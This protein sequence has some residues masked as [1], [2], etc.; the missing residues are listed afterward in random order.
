MRRTRILAACVAASLAGALIA[1]AQEI[2][3]PRVYVP[4]PPAPNPASS[5]GAVTQPTED[6]AAPGAPPPLSP[7]AAGAEV[8]PGE[9]QAVVSPSP[10]GR[11][12]GSGPPDAAFAASAV[13]ASSFSDLVDGI[14][15]E[16]GPGEALGVTGPRPT[17]PGYGL[18]A[19]S[20][21]AQIA[22]DAYQAFP[23]PRLGPTPVANVRIL[24]N[25]LGLDPLEEWS[26][27]RTFGWVEGGYTGASVGPGLLSVQTRQNRFGDEFLLNQIGWVIEKPLRSDQFDL[28][29]V[30]RYFAGADAALGAPKGGI[31]SS[32]NPHFGQDFRDL[33]LSMHLPVLTENGVDFR[34]GRMNTIIGYNG[35]LAPY[36]PFY[37]SDYQFF[38]LQDG[39]FTGFLLDFKIS[40]RLSIWSGMTLGANTFFVNRT[41]NSYCYIGQVNYWLT[42]E[43]R[44]R[45]TAS[46]YTGP[47]ALFS[48]PGLSG[49]HDTMVE[50]RMQ[51]AWSPRLTQ[52]IQS[53]MGW[54]SGTP[55]G[56]SGAYGVY[57]I[58]LYHFT[59]TLDINWRSEWFDDAMGTRT[60][61]KANYAE[62]TGGLNWHPLRWLE[63][64]P[65]IR[66]D[67][68]DA[69]V[70]GRNGAHNYRDMLTG[71]ISFLTKF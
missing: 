54:D 25:L 26:N 55:V 22:E 9:P 33:Y 29:F 53:N 3:P 34:I 50:L 37:S 27:I 64:R 8:P 13:G 7:A 31:D 45:L 40:S 28:G 1:D 51:H 12:V 35:F 21:P 38:Y 23:V 65:E 49:N 32:P 59:N 62:V 47:H 20:L 48:A 36:R 2:P 30:M 60:G 44:T 52:V 41:S 69:P 42:D 19:E 56:T 17:T 61:I 67:F 46:V 11:A 10:L 15:V 68:A 57:N 58:F 14:E 71:G 43:Q 39:A 66:G 63:L 16:L 4:S 18:E 5:S 24:M 6:V 70:F